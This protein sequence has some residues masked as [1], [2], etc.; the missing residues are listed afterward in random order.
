MIA[1]PIE[2]ARL[3]LKGGGHSNVDFCILNRRVETGEEADAWARL[4]KEAPALLELAHRVA[5]HFADT[6]APIGIEARG[7]LG[8]LGKL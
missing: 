5:A 3:P 8:R 6:D 1:G 4:F 2:I 7:I